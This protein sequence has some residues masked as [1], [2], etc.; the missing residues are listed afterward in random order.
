MSTPLI[1]VIVATYF[2]EKE[3]LLATLRSIVLQKECPF[4][5]IITD[6]G[7]KTFFQ[8]DIRSFLDNLGCCDYQILAHEK[9]QGTVKNL[10]DGALL[11]K[12]KYVKTISPGDL[13]YDA[14]TLHDACA[15]MERY[16]AR[17]AFGDMAVYAYTHKLQ[18]IRLFHPVDDRIYRA[19]QKRY[20]YRKALKHQMV[21]ADLICGAADLYERQTFCNAME[22]INGVVTYAEDSAYQLFAA[23]NTRI[24][25]FPQKLVWYEHGTGISTNSN[26]PL[27]SRI[28]TDFYRFYHMLKETCPNLP[29]LNRT[30]RFWNRRLQGSKVKKLIFKFLTVDK[31]LFSLRRRLLIK[32]RRVEQDDT[33]FYQCTKEA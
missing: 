33:F 12:G 4:E 20:N 16:H 28:D 19:E 27:F 21:Y 6:D 3:K 24:Y 1:S 11:A 7:S 29:F 30:L 9:N 25:K 18:M 13:L 5:I 22:K 23:E 2:P 14:Y 15:F 26:S 32:T 17:V 31:V 10:L 8:E